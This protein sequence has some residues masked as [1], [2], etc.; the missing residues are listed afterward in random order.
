MSDFVGRDGELS[1]LD[2]ALARALGGSGNCVAVSGEPGIGKSRLIAEAR[3]RAG[4][5]G[6]H[7]VAGS[8]QEQDRM[9][10]LAPLRMLLDV[11]GSH[12]SGQGQL[13][14][15]ESLFKL[16]TSVLQQRIIIQPLLLTIED[17][18]WCD[19]ATRHFLVT[20]LKQL[21]SWAM[22]LILSYRTPAS[23]TALGELP[24]ELQ[25]SPHT[26][27]LELQPL[28]RYDVA[29]IM[30]SKASTSW[31]KRFYFLKRVYDATGGNPLFVE[32]LCLSSTATESV[33]PETD[34]R[35]LHPLPQAAVPR[36][37]RRIIRNRVQQV[38]PPA[39]RVADICAVHGRNFDLP[40]LE[41]ITAYPRVALTS[42]CEEL[43]A[44]R[45]AMRTEEGRFVFR[46]AMV[47]EALFDRLL[48]RERRAIHKVLLRA[49]EGVYDD[50]LEEH[51]GDLTYHAYEAGYWESAVHYAR[52]AAEQALALHAPAA[53]AAQYTRAIE[54][55]QRESQAPS[56]ELHCGRATAFQK[57]GEIDRA[58]TDCA[59]AL[60]SAR[61]AGDRQAERTVMRKLLGL[62]P[63]LP[64]AHA[65]D[66]YRQIVDEMK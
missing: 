17:L 3:R 24:D 27:I 23:D 50:V 14:T 64:Q 60:D 15:A 31:P 11:T 25:H 33:S 30:R 38:S 26:Q 61:T 49:L 4:R 40:V 2:E 7:T 43:V 62:L 58:L 6:F 21:P 22:L 53:A 5:L 66:Y 28:N 35:G 18:H 20:L 37:V 36:S 32:E 54:A 52:L 45:L 51:L 56:W 42:I 46:H 1:I 47:R 10:A 19:D 8:C 65:S 39:Q 44:E 63:F 57:M 55:A 41:V 29:Q 9:I 13:P 48:V 34:L 16:M 59:T 12:R